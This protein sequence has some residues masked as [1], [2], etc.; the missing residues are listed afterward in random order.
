MGI[1]V[2]GISQEKKHLNDVINEGKGRK[3]SREV[4]SAMM[5]IGGRVGY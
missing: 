2:K 5:P 1:K 4:Q 3:V